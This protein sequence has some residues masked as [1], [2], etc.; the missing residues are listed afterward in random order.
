MVDSLIVKMR[1]FHIR[2]CEQFALDGDAGSKPRLGTAVSDH[3]CPAL[4]IV[5]VCRCIA[6]KF[7]L[8]KPICLLLG[9]FCLSMFSMPNY[10]KGHPKTCAF[11]QNQGP[12]TMQK[13]P[14]SLLWP[15]T[16]ATPLSLCMYVQGS[17]DY[18][19]F[20]THWKNG[21]HGLLVPRHVLTAWVSYML[22][23]SPGSAFCEKLLPW[24]FVL[25]KVLT[26]FYQIYCSPI[27]LQT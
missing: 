12:A 3:Q 15:T 22:V 5:C 1:R 8:C 14:L 13:A 20:V 17:K 21:E 9:E 18:H 25:L 16:P 24:V 2:G 19:H 7:M 4:Y 27:P 26:F 23:S 6:T 10:P 11:S